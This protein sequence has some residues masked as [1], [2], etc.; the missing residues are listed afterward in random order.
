[1]GTAGLPRE[2]GRVVSDSDALK[3]S[4]TV[5]IRAW[6]FH[7]FR[8]FPRL[9]PHSL[10]YGNYQPLPLPQGGSYQPSMSME[11]YMTAGFSFWRT[12]RRSRESRRLWGYTPLLEVGPPSPVH[13]VI[14]GCAQGRMGGLVRSSSPAAVEMLPQAIGR[15]ADSE[16]IAAVC[17]VLAPRGADGVA[18]GLA[19]AVAAAVAGSSR[20][21]EPSGRTT[22]GGE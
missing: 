4:W 15:I 16:H 6:P 14:Q 7:L 18:A 17:A 10:T 1:M 20:P 9:G 19:V 3:S 11:V 5:L 22:P 12:R 13:F 8:I 21:G 2:A